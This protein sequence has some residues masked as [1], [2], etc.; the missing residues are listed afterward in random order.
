MDT[1]QDNRAAFASMMHGL[2]ARFS[3]WLIRNEI[4][5][6]SES[7]KNVDKPLKTEFFLEHSTGSWRRITSCALTPVL[8]L[9][10]KPKIPLEAR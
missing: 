6:G 7:P 1:A 8:G 10:L 3:L 9:A 2:L 4:A 5:E